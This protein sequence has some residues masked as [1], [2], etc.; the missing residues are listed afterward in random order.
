MKPAVMQDWHLFLF[1]F[2]G[3]SAHLIM[4]TSQEDK[5]DM[6]GNKLSAKDTELFYELF[7]MLLDYA[8][9]KHDKKHDLMEDVKNQRVDQ[10]NALDL[11]ELVFDH[12]G[13][14]EECIEENKDK[15]TEE[16]EDILRSWKNFRRGT[17]F[18][19]RFLKSGAA[20]MDES[21]DVYIVKGLTDSIEDMFMGMK[22]VAT[23][24]VLLP[25]RDAIISDGLYMTMPVSFGGGIKRNLKETYNE[26]KAEGRYYT[27]MPEE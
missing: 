14:I 17:F 11:S 9:R 10:R 1:E 20:F 16:K 26:A 21:N 7:F 5:Q 6:K 19:E 2:T 12:P 15:L 27:E 18:I 8:G 25:F 23:K 3:L 13:I 24:T 22:P 4:E